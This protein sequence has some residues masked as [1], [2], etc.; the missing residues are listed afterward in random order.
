[1]GNENEIKEAERRGFEVANH[2]WSHPKLSEKDAATILSEYNQVK[3]RLDSILGVNRD[4]LLRPPYLAVNDTVK[5]TLPVPLINCG[6][7]SGDWNNASV[8]DM[9][10]MIQ[11]AANNGSLNGKVVLMHETNDRT[12][13]AVEQL[14]PWLAQNGYAIVTVSEMFKYNGKDLFAGNVYKGCF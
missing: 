7:D 9:V 2:T 13:Q 14:C 1:M 10:S 6:I 11:T 4:Y 8:A 3:N 12:P 5:K